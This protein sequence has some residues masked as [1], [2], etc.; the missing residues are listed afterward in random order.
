MLEAI[1]HVGASISLRGS[2][3]TTKAGSPT[4]ANASRTMIKM[5]VY[6]YISIYVCVLF[7]W[8]LGLEIRGS[9]FTG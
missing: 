1:N 5:C 4:L 7:V 8:D 6:L 2:T 3:Y 9:E